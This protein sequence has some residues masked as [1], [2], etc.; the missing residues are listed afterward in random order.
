MT[1]TPLLTDMRER[2]ARAD[3]G[4]GCAAWRGVAFLPATGATLAR[5]LTGGMVLVAHTGSAHLG[6]VVDRALVR[7][8][9]WARP[10]LVTAAGSPDHTAQ[11]VDLP[12]VIGFRHA[13][14]WSLALGEGRAH[15]TLHAIVAPGRPEVH[16]QLRLDPV[17]AGRI[18]EHG[19]PRHPEGRWPPA[20]A[21]LVL[22]TA[23]VATLT[24]L[25]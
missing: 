1:S 5:S 16:V 3:R 12:E 6:V 2:R 10:A 22:L 25:S 4:T 24:F 14:S 19:V 13:D 23:V 7:A 18:A 15:L 11:E 21:L 20:L 17:L 9:A 8:V